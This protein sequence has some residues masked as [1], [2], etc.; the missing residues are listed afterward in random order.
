[1]LRNFPQSYTLLNASPI[2]GLFDLDHID[3]TWLK[4]GSGVLASG[5]HIRKL[6]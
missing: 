4:W 2:K 6:E 5:A 3:L 1:M